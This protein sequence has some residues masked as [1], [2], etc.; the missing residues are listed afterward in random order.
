MILIFQVIALNW[1]GKFGDDCGDYPPDRSVKMR[2]L[3]ACYT[4]KAVWQTYRE[5]AQ[6]TVNLN[7]Y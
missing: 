2:V 6:E 7:V 4:I 1:L 3:P 5:W